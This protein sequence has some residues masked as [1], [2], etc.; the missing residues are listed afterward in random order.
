MLFQPSCGEI[1]ETK[2]S[3]NPGVLP[4]HGGL[5]SQLILRSGDMKNAVLQSFFSNLQN[6][7]QKIFKYKSNGKIKNARPTRS[8]V[9]TLLDVDGISP[10]ISQLKL[11]RL[12]FCFFCGWKKFQKIFSEWVFP[13]IGVPQNGWFI[14]E[15]PIKMD[16]LGVPLFSETSKWWFNGDLSWYNP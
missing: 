2:T 14:M 7:H 6:L 11:P 9:L 4:V 8:C 15:N 16:D 1:A 10:H 12:G 3:Q 5:W 13:K